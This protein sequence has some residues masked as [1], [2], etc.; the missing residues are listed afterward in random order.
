MISRLRLMFLVVIWGSLMR[1]Y[2][3][4]FNL[5]K[6]NLGWWREGLADKLLGFSL[7]WSKMRKI[8]N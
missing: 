5:L 6:K 2:P 7:E 3:I 4:A 1:K 8:W